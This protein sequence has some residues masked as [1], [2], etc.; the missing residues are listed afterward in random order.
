MKESSED[1]ISGELRGIK[2]IGPARQKWLQET[3]NIM[4]IDDLAMA[5]WESIEFEVSQDDDIIIPRREIQN[6]ITQA[7]SQQA[8]MSQPKAAPQSLEEIVE[9]EE[10]ELNDPIELIPSPI[11]PPSLSVRITQIKII[12]SDLIQ[13]SIVPGQSTVPILWRHQP[14]AIDVQFEIETAVE[15][16]IETVIDSALQDSIAAATYHLQCHAQNRITQ[17]ISILESPFSSPLISDQTSYD[18]RLPNFQ[19]DIGIY[20]LQIWVT[21]QGLRAVGY[22]D[23]PLIQIT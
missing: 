8:T 3:L 16:V 20:R 10:I 1:T 7:R 9:I 15:T 22:F 2:G 14:F 12:Q 19:L 6:W 11:V 4:T 5:A 23:I 21:L 17:Q 18:S 13:H